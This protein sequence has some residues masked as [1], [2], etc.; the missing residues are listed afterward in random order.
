MRIQSKCLA[1]ILGVML[2]LGLLSCKKSP[3][4]GPD[5][6]AIVNQTEI[7]NSD[8][9]KVYQNRIKTAGLPQSPEEVS[10]L[11]LNILSQL[12]NNEILMQRAAKDNLTAA[13]AEVASKFAEFKKDYTEEKFQQFLKD[14]GI[15]ADD[16]RKELRKDATIEKLYNKEITSKIT[17]SEAEITDYFNRNKQNYNL[18]ESWH[19]QH[20]L[21]TPFPDQQLNNAKSDDAKTDDEA[22]QKVQTLLRRILGGEDF[23]IIAKDYSEDPTSA[24]NGGDLRLLSAQQLESIDPRFRQVVQ[25]L[26]VGE[27]YPSPVPTKYG[28]HI[29]KLLEK[30]RGGQHDLTDP[31]VQADIRQIIFNRKETLLKTAYLEVVR[32]EATVQNFL[33][34]KILEDI[35]KA[36]RPVSSK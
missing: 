5:T 19:V 18:P 24:P 17:V 31:K 7:K 35:N 14:Q 11:R 29:I 21:V 16:L 1:A 36:V 27:T 8:A 13:E 33:A 26:R 22:R 15:T 3:T 10:T 9:E 2:L 25:S 28:Y 6:A 12:I 34:K 23:G 20:I 32:N 4:V 30:E